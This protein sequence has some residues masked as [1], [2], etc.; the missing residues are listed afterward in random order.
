MPF[1]D[2]DGHLIKA[3]QKE[4]HGTASDLIK[5]KLANRNWSLKRL[6]NLA[7]FGIG[8]LNIG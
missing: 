7:R 8:R 4:K 2:V 6:I 5:K 3:F 1:T